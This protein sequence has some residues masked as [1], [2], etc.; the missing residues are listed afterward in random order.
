M[1]FFEK[2]NHYGK[3]LDHDNSS[4]SSIRIENLPTDNCRKEPSIKVTE[5][6]NIIEDLLT[7]HANVAIAKGFSRLQF[8]SDLDNG[9]KKRFIDLYPVQMSAK[10]TDENG[11][12]NASST[13]FDTYT[14]ILQMGAILNTVPVWKKSHTLRV[15]VFV[16]YLG[17]VKGE[18]A[19]IQALLEKLRI[20]AEILVLCLSSGLETYD[21]IV[22][23]KADS[24]GIVEKYLGSYYWWQ[25]IQQ[26]RADYSSSSPYNMGSRPTAIAG[27]KLEEVLKHKRRRSTISSLQRLGVSFSM[28]TSNL[29]RSNTSKVSGYRD[30]AVDSS[31]DSSDEQDTESESEE[32]DSDERARRILSLRRRKSDSTIVRKSQK[33]GETAGSSKLSSRPPLLKTLSYSEDIKDKNRARKLQP[34]FANTMTPPASILDDDEARSSGASRSIAFDDLPKPKRE[35]ES[36]RAPLLS[37]TPSQYYSSDSDASSVHNSLSFNDLPAKAQH[38]ILN[39][40]MRKHSQDS[41]VLFSTLP[42]PAV[43]THSSEAESADY[44]DSLD[45]LCQQLPPIILL[46]SQSMTVTTAL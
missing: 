7:M 25:E 10:I 23:G 31:S 30:V 38:V 13:N 35:Q 18:S 22:K 39:D 42:A 24:S 19:R 4:E 1:G 20:N 11:A 8:P 37:E 26:F 29:R 6:V 41:V 32:S 46:H 16:E 40:L 45:L 12:L 15:I 28:Q 2:K 33:Q 21:V 36:E 17:D 27:A 44:V 9:E 14:L 34:N 43:G 3:S 5:W